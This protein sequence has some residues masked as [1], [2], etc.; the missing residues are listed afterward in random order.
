MYALKPAKVTTLLATLPPNKKDR[1]ILLISYACPRTERSAYLITI[2]S[3]TIHTCFQIIKLELS[4]SCY[5]N[6]SLHLVVPPLSPIPLPILPSWGCPQVKILFC[7]YKKSFIYQ[8]CSI[9]LPEYWFC[10]HKLILAH[11][12]AEKETWPASSHLDLPLGR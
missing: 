10:S 3:I 2:S 8:G 7:P 4:F 6:S 5:Q 1:V 9:K 11:R 12:N